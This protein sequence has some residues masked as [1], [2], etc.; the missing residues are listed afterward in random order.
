MARLT[1][2]QPGMAKVDTVPVTSIGVTVTAGTGEVI[3]GWVMARR[4]ICIANA[5]VAERGIAP[6]GCVVT[7]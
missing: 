4:A 5:I 3:A 6:V 1:V 2:R 7:V